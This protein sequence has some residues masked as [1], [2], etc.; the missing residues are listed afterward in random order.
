MTDTYAEELLIKKFLELEGLI[1]IP[2]SEIEDKD[3]EVEEDEE[4]PTPPSENEINNEEEKEYFYP[5]VAFP[6]ESFERPDDGYWYE[7]YMIPAIPNQIELGTEARSRWTGIMQ[8]NICVPKD[9][10]TRALNARYDA[11]A[12]LFRSGLYL[13]GV[14][15]VRTY[16]TSALDDG[17]Y[18]V[19][20][21]SVEWWA[22]LDR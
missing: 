7:I 13:E 14:R 8:I 22:D 2:Y 20:P 21:V 15:V 3:E 6:N 19:L 10:G 1:K 4:L 11:I 18:T 9:S 12:S 5:E 17:D 16:R